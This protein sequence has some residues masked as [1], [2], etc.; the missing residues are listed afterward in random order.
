MSVAPGPSARS[1]DD[2]Q[3]ILD[4]RESSPAR[5]IV[6]EKY[7]ES[8]QK[9]RR[10]RKSRLLV[11][12]FGG[13]SLSSPSRIRRACET[14]AREYSLGNRLAVVVSAVGRTT[15]EL[16]ELTNG[17]AEIVE[18]DRDDILAM[19]ERTSGRIFAASLKSQGIQVRYFDPSDRDWPV[20]TDDKFQDAN[21]VGTRCISRIQSYVKPVIDNGIVPVIAGFVGR[22]RDGR[23]STLGRGGSDTTALLLA[24]ALEAD[25]VV[26]VTSVNGILT[27]DPRLVKDARPLPKIDIRA[28]TGIADTGKKFIHRKALQFKDPRINVRVLSSTATKL[29]SEGTLITGGPMPDLEVRVHNPHPV[30]SVTLVGRS[31]SRRPEF[32]RKVARV[33]GPILEAASQDEDSAILYLKQTRSIGEKLGQLHR[34]VRDDRNGIALAARMNNA[35]ISV[36]GVGLEE[37]PGV[38]AKIAETLRSNGANVFGLLTISSSVLVLVEWAKRKSAARTIKIALEDN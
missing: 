19:G 25:E 23:I 14:I 15:D 26:L 37:T 8:R 1:H 3:E 4:V 33:A 32:M 20:I 10:T 7:V 27:A 6:V 5:P 24:T 11:V 38:V 21:P 28:L 34:I 13:S 16:F 31:L 36:K 22:T 9:H 17:G 30:A 35:L 18:A 29:D 2:S 12:K